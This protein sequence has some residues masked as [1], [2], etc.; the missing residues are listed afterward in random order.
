MFLRGGER[1]PSKSRLTAKEDYIL[2]T[3]SFQDGIFL[4]RWLLTHGHSAYCYLKRQHITHGQHHP[5]QL[6]HFPHLRQ[7]SLDRFSWTS[8]H[9]PLSQE[10]LLLPTARSMGRANQAVEKPYP[11]MYK[12]FPPSI[13]WAPW[14]HRSQASSTESPKLVRISC[15]T[16]NQTSPVPV[17]PMNQAGSTLHSKSSPFSCSPYPCSL[18][19][20]VHTHEFTLGLRRH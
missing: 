18:P 13:T 15:A 2:C 10:F 16:K 20:D 8:G 12:P 11:A 14:G 7:E 4:R 3:F 1:L 9:V 19:A 5:R 6:N 17:A